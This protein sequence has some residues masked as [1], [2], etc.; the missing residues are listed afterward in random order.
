MKHRK[1]NKYNNNINRRINKI[2]YNKIMIKLKLNFNN[3]MI[4][5]NV[6]TYQIKIHKI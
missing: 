4:W 2:I 1:L 5:I 3:K 6:K